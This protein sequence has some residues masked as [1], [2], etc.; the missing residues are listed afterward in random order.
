M[1]TFYM[2]TYTVSEARERLADILNSVERGE[3]VSITKH[4][5][6]IAR[7]THP[8]VA[9]DSVAVPPPGFLKAQGWSV[10]ITADFD[11]IP[12]GFEDYV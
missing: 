7:I 5:R 10:E 11:A 6:P 1:Y 8:P 9:S 3:E 4:G 12:E 2:K